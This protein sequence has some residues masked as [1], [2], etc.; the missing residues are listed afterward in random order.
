MKNILYTILLIAS[1]GTT[2]IGCDGTDAVNTTQSDVDI[3]S[4]DDNKF[5]TI[6]KLAAEQGNGLAQFN[7]GLM[8]Y[9]GKGTIQDYKEAFKWFQKSA[10]EGSSLGQRS[11]GKMYIE[12]NGIAKNY[13]KGIK[14]YK[15]S[16]EQGNSMSQGL[17]GMIY[18]AGDKVDQD[19]V[20]AHMYFN[21][22]TV[23]GNENFSE[24]RY[25]I[26][27]LMTSL[28]IE[29]AQKLAREWINSHQ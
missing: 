15:K 4:T 23:K 8:Y 26:S 14:W 28:Q 19:L 21:I 16:A 12:G 24:H 11:L 1:I 13:K 22:A 7:L 5:K 20:L 27:K 9:Q 6:L 2:I 10:E 25:F 17:L 3:Q 18:L 29:K